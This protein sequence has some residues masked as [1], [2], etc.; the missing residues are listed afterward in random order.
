MSASIR[1]KLPKVQDGAEELEKGDPSLPDPVPAALLSDRDWV[2]PG[3]YGSLLVCGQGMGPS[4]GHNDAGIKEINRVCCPADLVPHDFVDDIRTIPAT[5]F[6]DPAVVLEKFNVYIERMTKLGVPLH[7]KPGKFFLPTTAFEWIG[8]RFCSVRNLIGIA[9]GRIERAVLKISRSL[10]QSS[11]K[12]YGYLTRDPARP[13]LPVKLVAE[14]RGII[15]SL[16]LV[17]RGSVPAFVKEA[18]RIITS[19]GAEAKWARGERS[20]D[21]LVRVTP[22]LLR[23]L[24]WWIMVLTDKWNTE[25]DDS[26]LGRMIVQDDPTSSRAGAH[27]WEPVLPHP[28]SGYLDMHVTNLVRIKIDASKEGWGASV[29]FFGQEM[30]TFGS[31]WSE[32]EKYEAAV[33]ST[34]APNCPSFAKAHSTVWEATAV[35]WLMAVDLGKRLRGH[36]IFVESDNM[37]TV[38]LLAKSFALDQADPGQFSSIAMAEIGLKVRLW[39]LRLRCVVSGQHIKGTDNWYADSVSRLLVRPADVDPFPARFCSRRTLNAILQTCKVRFNVEAFGPLPG[40]PGG[41]LA[42]ASLRGTSY[43]LLRPFFDSATQVLASPHN[44]VWMFPPVELS[45]QVLKVLYKALGAAADD[46]RP[47]AAVALMIRADWRR[48]F[49]FRVAAWETLASFKPGE[50]R[51]CAPVAAPDNILTVPVRDLPVEEHAWM[52]ISN[53]SRVWWSRLQPTTFSNRLINRFLDR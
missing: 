20:Y 28:K 13:Q 24:Q 10:A 17:T 34:L 46:Q 39:E 42:A 33:G 12:P 11:D 8:W 32:C 25:D 22:I 35:L 6:E 52:L 44:V 27:L 29:A 31:L 7:T 21:P 40:T 2:P 30:E 9:P 18:S 26:F 51:F 5:P 48:R 47:R 50:Q 53:K 1:A 41:F 15:I 4:P 37:P 49:Q 43:S 36:T 23:G 19:T 16:E 14:F 45:Q 3:A 38:S